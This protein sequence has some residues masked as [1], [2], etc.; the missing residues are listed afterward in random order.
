MWGLSILDA[1]MTVAAIA[2][3]AWRGS[4][5]D[6]ADMYGAARRMKVALVHGDRNGAREAE[7]DLVVLVA[8]VLGHQ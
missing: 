8:R 1:T 2:A 6:V 4:K 7:R 3:V 5:A